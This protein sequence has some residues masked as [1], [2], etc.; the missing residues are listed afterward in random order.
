MV[1][2]N[3]LGS[4]LD[5]TFCFLQLKKKKKNPEYVRTIFSF[6]GTLRHKTHILHVRYFFNSPLWAA[7]TPWPQTVL[8]LLLLPSLKL[9]PFIRTPLG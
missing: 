7:E 8:C 1:E 5:F 9:L 2:Y 6:Q 4:F 3:F